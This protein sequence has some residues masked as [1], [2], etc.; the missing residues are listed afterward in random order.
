MR[1]AGG[2]LVKV[3]DATFAY[4]ADH[5]RISVFY[6]LAKVAVNRLAWSQGHELA[7]RGA[8][9]LAIS[10]GWLRAEM[11]LEAFAT[12]EANWRQAGPPAASTTA[13][14]TPR[15]T[16]PCTDSAGADVPNRHGEPSPLHLV[17]RP[18]R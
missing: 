10:P 18:S 16:R 4:N 13:N 7:D 17:D 1:R 8:T 5:Y 11:M 2:L 15:W 9:A 14:A 3:T 6:D 12:T